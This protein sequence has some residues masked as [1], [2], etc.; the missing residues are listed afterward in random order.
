MAKDK[1]NID[2]MKLNDEKR[3]EKCTDEE[4]N[5]VVGGADTMFPPVIPWTCPSCGHYNNTTKGFSI[6]KFCVICG[7]P[8]PP[9]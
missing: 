5:E 6:V 4:L 9:K 8:M 3:V 7:E 2:E 1:I